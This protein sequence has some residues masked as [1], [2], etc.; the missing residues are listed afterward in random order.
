MLVPGLDA[1]LRPAALQKWG[2]AGTRTGVR[3]AATQFLESSKK[4]A[5]EGPLWKDW[6]NISMRFT[7]SSKVQVRTELDLCLYIHPRGFKAIADSCKCFG[8]CAL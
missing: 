2:Q 8:I 5:S 1:R 3:V 4:S 6:G 7:A